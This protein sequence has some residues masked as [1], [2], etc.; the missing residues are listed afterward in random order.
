MAI[1]INWVSKVIFVPQSYLTRSGLNAFQLDVNQFRMDLN[2]LQASPEGMSF[3]TTHSHNTTVTIAGVTL[4]RVVEL[5][6][7]YTVLFENGSYTVDLI[8]ANTNI[9]D[10][11]IFNQV[12]INSNNSAGLQVVETGSGL[13]IEQDDTLN[14]IKGKLESLFLIVDLIRKF[15]TNRTKINKTDNSLT[16][17]DDDNVTPIVR[18]QL[19][20]QNGQP[21]IDV[22]H[23]RLPTDVSE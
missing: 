18:H 9:G 8:N 6:N 10:F 3:D 15:V 11:S 19:K 4:A 2:S 20:D 23:E 13:S 5:I 22:I 21:S 7:G 17:F 1:S 12:R 16:L 14:F